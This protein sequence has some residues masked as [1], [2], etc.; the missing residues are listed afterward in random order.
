MIG[1]YQNDAVLVQ[2]TSSYP[3]FHAK[4]RK[5]P[6]LNHFNEQKLGANWEAKRMPDLE[7]SLK[8]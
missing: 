5:A 3:K 8:F 2:T 4:P 7:S 6:F 1:L